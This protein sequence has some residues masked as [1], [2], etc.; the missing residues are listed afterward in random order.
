MRI[1]GPLNIF[2]SSNQ[3]I[4]KEYGMGL[5][6]SR[7]AGNNYIGILADY[8]VLGMIDA[9]DHQSAGT[10]SLFLGFDW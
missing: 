5:C 3:E 2:L 7:N 4:A 9:S 1:V 10:V 6:C 8:G